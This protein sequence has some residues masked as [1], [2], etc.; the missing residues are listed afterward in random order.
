LIVPGTGLPPHA[1][2][3]PVI[4]ILP[5]GA[6]QKPHPASRDWVFHFVCFAKQALHASKI[7]NPSSSMRGFCARDGILLKCEVCHSF[8]I[9]QDK[10]WAIFELLVFI[11]LV[12]LTRTQQ[13]S[14][15][16]GI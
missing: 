2:H 1:L 7:K 10:T 13:F 15:E 4:Q 11:H 3:V 12:L 16:T 5:R 8:Y 6:I 9:E 14:K